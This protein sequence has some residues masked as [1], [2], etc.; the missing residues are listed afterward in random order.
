DAWYWWFTSIAEAFDFWV[1]LEHPELRTLAR[2]QLLHG[3]GLQPQANS[4]T[5]TPYDELPPPSYATSPSSSTSGLVFADPFP[6]SPLEELQGLP[7]FFGNL[8]PASPPSPVAWESTALRTSEWRAS[9]DPAPATTTFMGPAEDHGMPP[10]RRLSTAA[11]SGAAGAG[12][13][14]AVKAGRRL[15]VTE[16]TFD[17]I[18]DAVTDYPGAYFKPCASMTDA[19]AWLGVG[20]G[21]EET[22]HHRPF[23]SAFMKPFY[24]VTYSYRSTCTFGRGTVGQDMFALLEMNQM[25]HEMCSYL[26]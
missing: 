17:G 2:S 23:I 7:P 19:L 25:E 14:W 12:Q 15:G 16:G 6:D 1:Y 10:A 22:G 4:A 8:R 18:L 9:L 13:Y 5:T 21:G 24:D 20:G 3:A 11:G 26:Q